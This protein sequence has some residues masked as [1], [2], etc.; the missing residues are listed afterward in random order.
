LLL[1]LLFFSGKKHL[2]F[3]TNKAY[4]ESTNQTVMKPKLIN[5]TPHSVDIQTSPEY[6]ATIPPTAPPARVDVSTKDIG[7]FEGIQLVIPTFGHT[8]DLPAPEPGTFLIVSHVVKDAHP[9]RFDLLTPSRPIRDEAGRVIAAG[10]LSV[11]N[12]DRPINPYPGTETHLRAIQIM[13]ESNQ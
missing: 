7:H 5:L 10:S 4:I 6:T 13:K 11:Q 12:P 8:V 1:S 3:A 9:S 2:D